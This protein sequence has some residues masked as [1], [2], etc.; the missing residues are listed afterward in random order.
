MGF[1][2]FQGWQC[3][4]AVAHYAAATWVLV[5]TDGGVGWKVPAVLRFNIWTSNDGG[6]CAGDGG[7]TIDEYEYVLPAAI[8]TGALVASFSYFSGTHHAIAAYYGERFERHLI[9]HKGVSVL[10]WMDY[11]WSASLMLMTDS[12][13]WL[14]PGS[15]Q[16]LVLTFCTMWLVIVAGYGSEVAWSS[17]DNNGHA[18][19]IF[20]LAFT[21]FVCAWAMTWS[22]FIAALHPPED[23]LP[24]RTSFADSFVS[25]APEASSPPSFV[26]VILVWLFITYVSFP[27]LHCYRL[28]AGT[29]EADSIIYV[30]S[31]YSV[32]SFC[33]KIPLLAVYGTAVSAR[34]NRITV[35]IQ[36]QMADVDE[37]DD[38]TFV[39]LGVSA[40]LSFVLGLVM[41]WDINKNGTQYY[42]TVR[43]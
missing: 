9:E 23:S 4:L 39:A 43:T 7:C 3:I 14:A 15:V 29:T 37:V 20:L 6:T 2:R 12:L 36:E 31:V 24:L 28:Y 26:I 21:P 35:G 13:L 33:A 42:K 18:K 25:K 11:C 30:E 19:F 17:G 1:T 8:Y 38:N 16:T 22:T 32:L 34:A 41:L 40:G 5:V 27:A 10:R